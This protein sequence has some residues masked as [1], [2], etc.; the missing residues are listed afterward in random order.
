VLEIIATRR[1]EGATD[2][3][4]VL[5]ARAANAVNAAVSDDEFRTTPRALLFGHYTLPQFAAHLDPDLLGLP[6]SSPALPYV[7][8]ARERQKIMDALARVRQAQREQRHSAAVKSFQ[9]SH[10]VGIAPVVGDLLWVQLPADEGMVD[11]DSKRLQ[12][13]GPWECLAFDATHGKVH[14][15]LWLEND[16]SGAPLLATVHV[17]RTKPYMQQ[18]P[19]DSEFALDSVL[20]LDWETRAAPL[21]GLS[22]LPVGVEQKMTNARIAAERAALKAEGAARRAAKLAA[23]EA[24]AAAVAEA[25]RREGDVLRENARVTAEAERATTERLAAEAARAAVQRKELAQLAR[26][27]SEEIVSV[28]RIALRDGG[29]TPE[30]LVERRSGKVEWLQRSDAALASA[31]VQALIGEW[32]LRHSGQGRSGASEAA[33]RE[34]LLVIP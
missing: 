23:Q 10:R 29:D 21:G 22:R 5:A 2:A 11:K 3:I 18:R 12:V 28:K 33:K 17:R 13:S 9:A 4:E 16:A 6:A 32:E 8:Q 7:T 25:T 26:L 24:A 14:V 30:V 20:P 19:L 1:A 31:R 34:E 15:R 27:H